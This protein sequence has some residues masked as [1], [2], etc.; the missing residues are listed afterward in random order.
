M[1]LPGQTACRFGRTECRETLRGVGSFRHVR[2]TAPV[3]LAVSS[4]SNACTRH[5]KLNAD[6]VD[7]TVPAQQVFQG[8]P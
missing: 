5:R 1:R 8:S 6:E 4:A 7:L 3:T 2:T